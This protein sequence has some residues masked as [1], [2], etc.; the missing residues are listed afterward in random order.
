MICHEA[1]VYTWDDGTAIHKYPAGEG[2]SFFDALRNQMSKIS[3]EMLLGPLKI[4]RA[5]I[6]QCMNLES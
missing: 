2:D 6:S 5:S 3:S 4:L 1:I